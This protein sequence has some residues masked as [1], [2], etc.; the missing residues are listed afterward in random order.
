MPIRTR[1]A[2]LFAG[3]TAGLLLI[4]GATVYL[5]SY[6]ATMKA[7]TNRLELRAV[8]AARAFLERDESDASAYVALVREHASRL[9]YEVEY[10]LPADSARRLAYYDGGPPRDFVKDVLD[11]GKAFTRKA[12]VYY[13][14]ILYHD[15]EGDYVVAVSARPREEAVFLESLLRTKLI[16]ALICVL[17]AA[18]LGF[19]F[20][21]RILHPLRSITRRAAAIGA[22]SLDVRLAEASRPDELGALAS[23]FNVML[24][25]IEAAFESQ[26][27][28]VGHASHE[29]NTPLTTI[30]GEAEFA[31]AR[32][33][34]EEQYRQSFATIGAE[35][36]RLRAITAALLQLAR[37]RGGGPQ[38]T[39]AVS[40]QELLGAVRGI[41][42]T[43]EEKNQVSYRPTLEAENA[44][45]Q[46]NR[47]LLVQAVAN[48][49]LNGCKYS[50]NEPVAVE[51]RLAQNR[52]RL[53]VRDHGIGIP[54]T[55][56]KHIF[57]PFFRASNSLRHEGYGIGL[58]LTRTILR[59][60]GGNII[61]ESVEGGGTVVEMELPIKTA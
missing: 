20:A 51:A 54:A 24:D 5:L 17:L 33:R 47:A 11:D 48:V 1:I 10:V 28:F 41:V 38:I 52:L 29:L 39:E 19:L 44:M 8:V 40:V 30:L 21:E 50:S 57:D 25:R 15:N 27:A 16:V 4:S 45:L 31:L 55:E 13:Q 61:V 43:L 18:G 3:L 42:N 7:F 12:G 26:A 37:T 58:P 35:A 32:P 23:A 6:R 60:H 56:L 2:L 46:G 14:G 36:E 59:I 34:T 9:P 53:Q 49:V 22:D